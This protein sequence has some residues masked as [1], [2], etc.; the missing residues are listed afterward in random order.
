[1]GK[2]GQ[3]ETTMCLLVESHER[4]RGAVSLWQTCTRTA[5]ASKP[6]ASQPMS[7]HATGPRDLYMVPGGGLHGSVQ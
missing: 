6:T 2:L 1:M 3:V 7:G 4:G 5:E